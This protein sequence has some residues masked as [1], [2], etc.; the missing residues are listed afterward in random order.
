MTILDPILGAVSWMY[1]AIFLQPPNRFLISMAFWNA[2]TPSFH[3]RG[4]KKESSDQ[5]CRYCQMAR[6]NQKEHMSGTALFWTP[7]YQFP[8]GHVGHFSGYFDQKHM[9]GTALFWTPNSIENER[10]GFENERYFGEHMSG[11][12]SKTCHFRSDF[13]GDSRHVYEGFV[14]LL[15]KSCH[16]YNN[17]I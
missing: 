15:I 2:L 10:Y 6:F 14:F 5:M 7:K 1:H 17:Y 3:F 4:R 8:Q 9:S 11:T 12:A 16:I 13:R